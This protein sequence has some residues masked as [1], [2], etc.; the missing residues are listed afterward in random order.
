M[1][2]VA[3]TR[4]NWERLGLDEAPTDPMST[5]AEAVYHLGGRRVP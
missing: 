1:G 2:P 5:L 4:I 3:D